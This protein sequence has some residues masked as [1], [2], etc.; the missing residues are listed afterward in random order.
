VAV[1]QLLKRLQEFKV[2]L[3]CGFAPSTYR[4]QAF[5]FYL[6]CGSESVTYRLQE[7]L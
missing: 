6:Q 7:S 2:Y 3:Q 1:N 4:S 5:N